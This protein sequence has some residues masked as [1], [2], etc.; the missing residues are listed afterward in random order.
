MATS[1]SN[2]RL[3]TFM[4]FQKLREAIERHNVGSISNISSSA[5]EK[6]EDSSE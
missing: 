1:K 2:K 3:Q 5:S 4:Q 6:V